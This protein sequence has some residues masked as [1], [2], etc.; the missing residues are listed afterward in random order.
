MS[1]SRQ[2]T[3]KLSIRPLLSSPGLGFPTDQWVPVTNELKPN[4]ARQASAGLEYRQK[5]IKFHVRAFIKLVDNLLEF[6]EGSSMQNWEEKVTQGNGAAYGMEFYLA[7]EKGK[8]SGWIALSISKSERDFDEINFGK[9]FPYKY[10]R[11]HDFKI[12]II[13]SLAEKLN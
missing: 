8:T 9:T 11:R 12:V 1:R 6:K 3:P 13:R 7:K 2:D 5:N 4:I 10:D